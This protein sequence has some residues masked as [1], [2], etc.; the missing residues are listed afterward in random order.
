MSPFNADFA[1]STVLSYAYLFVRDFD[2][3]FAVV[4]VVLLVLGLGDDARVEY[5]R[6]NPYNININKDDQVH[7]EEKVRIFVFAQHY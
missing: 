4:A 3:V 5:A 2:I 7:H 1:S 6:R